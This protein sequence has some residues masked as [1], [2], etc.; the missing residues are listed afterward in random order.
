MRFVNPIPFARDIDRSRA[1]YRDRLGL[2]ILQDFGSFVLFEGGFAI[3]EGRSLEETVWQITSG[4]EEP[5]G[6]RNLLL[7]FE[8]EDVDAAFRNIAPYVELIH[9]V[10]KQAWG[11]RVF[12]FYD[13]DGHAIE[14]GEP[15]RL[16]DV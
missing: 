5:Y 7:Y 8:H 9:P 15:L 14:I 16:S 12:R 2:K 13:P 4:T 3:H 10:Q 1:F 6:R 11:Q